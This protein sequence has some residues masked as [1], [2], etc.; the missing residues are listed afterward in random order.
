[1]ESV[2]QLTSQ[3]LWKL[4]NCKYTSCYCEENVY[5]LCKDFVEKEKTHSFAE[6]TKHEAFAVFITNKAKKA[7]LR[8][9]KAGKGRYHNTVIW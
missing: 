4:E 7:E 2:P 8:N 6:N 5:L 3:E 9:Q 1:M